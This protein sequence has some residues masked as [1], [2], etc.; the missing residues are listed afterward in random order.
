MPPSDNDVPLCPNCV[1]P[2][3]NGVAFCQSC[4]A[5][6]SSF[7]ELDPIGKI[8]SETDTLI[9]AQSRV[10]RI[11]MIG[12][13]LTWGVPGIAAIGILV[14][15]I[16]VMIREPFGRV[17]FCMIAAVV[18]LFGFLIGCIWF[19]SVNLFLTTRNFVRG[20]ADRNRRQMK[21]R[22]DRRDRE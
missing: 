15:L 1:T 10:P 21:R 6:L 8:Q 18:T 22:R 13:W 12:E 5:P 9:K 7:A 4:G 17:D 19:S 16:V 20:R 14:W 11:V 3:Q 2:V